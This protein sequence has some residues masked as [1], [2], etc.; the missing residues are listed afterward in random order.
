MLER[1]PGKDHASAGGGHADPARGG[2][3]PMASRDT[4]VGAARLG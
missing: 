3:G 1:W 4:F 2:A